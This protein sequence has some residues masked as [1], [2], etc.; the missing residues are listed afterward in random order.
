MTYF[1]KRDRDHGQSLVTVDNMEH[2]LMV[3]RHIHVNVTGAGL[4]KSVM[5]VG[6]CH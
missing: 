2:V 1:P 3:S 5:L 4:E 6:N